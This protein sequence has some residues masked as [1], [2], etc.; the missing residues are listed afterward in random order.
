MPSSR[1]GRGSDWGGTVRARGISVTLTGN[2][3]AQTVGT[4]CGF[5]PA[6]RRFGLYLCGGGR[7]RCRTQN[8]RFAHSVQWRMVFLGRGPKQRR[9]RSLPYNVV[10][11]GPVVVHFSDDNLYSDDNIRCPMRCRGHRGR[12]QGDSILRNGDKGQ[13]EENTLT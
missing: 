2:S 1:G 12:A 13:G 7:S 6:R 4:T 9:Q 10:E 8:S 11:A 3:V 5:R